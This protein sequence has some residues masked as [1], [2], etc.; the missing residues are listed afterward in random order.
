MKSFTRNNPKFHSFYIARLDVQTQ[1]DD[2]TQTDDSNDL[3]P[4][5]TSN[6]ITKV[7]LLNSTNN[8]FNQ[9]N[10]ENWITKTEDSGISFFRTKTQKFFVLITHLPI[11]AKQKLLL[12]SVIWSDSIIPD[13]DW[14]DQKKMFVVSNEGSVV[15]AGDGVNRLLSQVNQSVLKKT[16]S[17][18]G[19]N[20]VYTGDDDYIL[21][22]S[23]S[24]KYPFTVY[25]WSS[26]EI[27]NYLIKKET[28]RQLVFV[29]LVLFIVLVIVYYFSIGFTK[30]IRMIS[31]RMVGLSRG[32]LDTKINIK[33]KDEIGNLAFI[34]NQTVDQLKELTIKE[35]ELSQ[36]KQELETANLIQTTL[37][38]SNR[39]DTKHTVVSA[40][41]EAMTKC[42][43]DWWS[44]FIIKDRYEYTCIA[45]ATG[46]GPSAAMV[47]SIAFT[48][49]ESVQQ[50]ILNGENLIQPSEILT[51]MNNLMG[52]DKLTG[53]TMTAAVILFDHESGEI[54][55]SNGGHLPMLYMQ[56]NKIK[57]FLKPGYVVGLEQFVPYSDHIIKASK[58]SRIILFTDGITEAVNRKGKQF[59]N[60]KLRK[61]LTRV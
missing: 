61:I 47:T 34:F 9:L 20:G 53:I 46:H 8:L 38:P 30:N 52:K 57:S 37:M 22:Y 31:A 60:S 59:G 23:G 32:D 24:T 48:V 55:Y 29:A 18:Q 43:G 1:D 27:A 39:L 28:M 54:T 15:Y 49:F 10:R 44:H 11:N 19:M 7:S 4:E 40:Y 13:L 26:Q 25:T 21:S 42:G 50:E 51:R 16:Y 45:D 58:M 12:V 6:K 33:S 3:D 2:S 35:V 14:T 17:Q 36:T 56:D 5:E 41:T